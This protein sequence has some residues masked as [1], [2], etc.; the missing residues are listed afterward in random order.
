MAPFWGAELGLVATTTNM[1]ST[2]SGWPE[3][4]LVWAD[5]ETDFVNTAAQA[6]EL[7]NDRGI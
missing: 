7:E 1:A 3:S 2:C 5:S 4:E 6:R